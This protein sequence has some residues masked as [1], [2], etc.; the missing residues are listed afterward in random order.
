MREPTSN[1]VNSRLPSWTGGEIPIHRDGVVDSRFIN[2]PSRPHKPVLPLFKPC[3]EQATSKK[4]VSRVIYLLSFILLTI[5]PTSSL[6]QLAAPTLSSQRTPLTITAMGQYQ[7]Y[8]LEA[9]HLTEASVPVSIGIPMGQSL[10]LGLRGSLAGAYSGLLQDVSGFSDVQAALTYTSLIGESSLAISLAGTIPSG[11]QKLTLPEFNTMI[12]LSQV[13]YRFQ[14]PAFGQGYSFMPNI[15]WATPIGDNVVLGLGVTYQVNGAYT[16]IVD[17]EDEYRAG[18]HVA[19]AAGLDV[20]LNPVTSLSGDVKYARYETD[21]LGEE[22][23][24]TAGERLST[25]LQFKRYFAFDEL[26][27]VALYRTHADGNNLATA[28][29]F[30][31]QNVR[32]LPN[33]AGAFLRY[34]KRLPG[35][36]VIG[37]QGAARYYGVTDAGIGLAGVRIGF[38]EQRLV[39]LGVFSEIPASNGLAFLLNFS[40]TAGTFS[41]VSGGV[42]FRASL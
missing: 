6:A 2:Q 34:S 3:S 10:Y 30:T 25:T 22:S 39:D 36:A 17:M 13:H 28:A 38:D 14:V 32:A 33:H 24:Y 8:G 15:S 29:A 23:W 1:N 40:G 11:T 27:L 12:L 41:G 9:S 26:R 37:L 4:R 21:K 20:R 31:D 5:L 35:G 42:G 18:N 16:P 19:F 7:R